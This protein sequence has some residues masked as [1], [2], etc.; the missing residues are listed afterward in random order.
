MKV[1]FW[2][3]PDFAVFTLDYL[4]QSDHEVLAVVTQPDAR[5]GRHKRLV[6]SPVKQF[7]QKHSLPI[8]QPANPNHGDFIRSLRELAPEVMVLVAYG[9]ILSKKLL[10]VPQYGFINVHFSLLPAYRGA[11]PI[12]AAILDDAGETGVTLIKLVPAMD[13]GPFLG[14]ERLAILP[15]DTRADLEIKLGQLA[16]LLLARIIPDLASGCPLD[17]QDESQA[18]YCRILKKEDGKIDWQ[19]PAAYIE[20]L[21]RAMYPWPEAHTA[22]VKADAQEQAQ[23][24]I[25][26]SCQVIA[27]AGHLPGKI[28]TVG[29]E[30]ID[31]A[32]GKDCLRIIRLQKAGKKELAAV[33]FLRGN[34]IRPGDRFI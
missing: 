25:V 27:G 29:Q 11:S 2:G 13:A 5:Q 9:K 6:A 21:V 30:G 18:S 3:T 1:I 20:R 7:A 23:R 33:D 28:V 24:I 17:Q 15:Q 34:N 10:T 4:R 19:Q 8:L 26:K 14:Q 31:V 12:A 22:M 16:P 32:T